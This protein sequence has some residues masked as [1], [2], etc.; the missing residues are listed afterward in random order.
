[1]GINSGPIDE[2]SDVND[3]RNVTGVAINMAQGVLDYGDAA[4]FFF[5]N[6]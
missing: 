5:P 6:E 3:R 2:V 4:I 1:M